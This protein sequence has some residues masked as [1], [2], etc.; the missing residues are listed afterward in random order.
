MNREL[1]YLIGTKVGFLIATLAW[2]I[3]LILD[4][5]MERWPSFSLIAVFLGAG[6]WGFSYGVLHEIDEE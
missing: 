3:P 2:G 1:L 6:L 5:G 4:Q